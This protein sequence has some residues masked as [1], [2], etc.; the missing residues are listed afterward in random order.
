MVKIQLFV[1]TYN[2]PHLVLNAIQ[3]AL[4]QNHDSFEII[5]SDNSTNDETEILVTQ[6]DDKRLLYR[7]RKPSIPVIDH[8]NVILKEVTSDYFMIFHDD[9]TMH[10]NMLEYLYNIISKRKEIVAIGANARVVENDKFRRKNFY[11]SLK[12]DVIILNLDQIIKAYSVPGFV[13]FPSYLYRK[14]VAQKL[15]FNSEHGGKH[16]DSAFIIDLLTLG[17]IVFVANPLMNYNIHVNQDSGIFEFTDGLK[18]IKY[19]TSLSKFQK[20]HRLIKRFRIQNIY[21]EL[22]YLLLSEN[23]SVFSKKYKRF[24]SLLLKYSFTEYFP[25]IILL[26]VYHKILNIMKMP[27]K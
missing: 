16:C 3:S 11:N 4:N 12:S 7:R 6:I 17:P 2:R 18:L 13:P 25:K 27:G 1:T 23:I 24:I 20:D 8:L 10:F 21:G 15:R 5:V 19:I 9:D 14:E 22:K 26:T